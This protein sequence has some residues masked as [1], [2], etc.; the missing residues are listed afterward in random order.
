MYS[1][2]NVFLAPTKLV[3]LSANILWHEPRRDTNLVNALIKAF[4]EYDETGS[5]CMA[6]VAMHTMIRLHALMCFWPLD[7]SQRKTIGPI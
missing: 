4:A 7:I 6:R 3:P 2:S 1:D 5:K